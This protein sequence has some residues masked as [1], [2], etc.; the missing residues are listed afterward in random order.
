MSNDIDAQRGQIDYDQEKSS[1]P[2]IIKVIGVGGGGG[3]A[4]NKMYENGEIAGVS[5]L[6]CNTDRQALDSKIVPSKLCI[7]LNTTKGLGAGAEPDRAQKAAEESKEEIKRSITEDETEMVF[8]TAGMGGGTGTG[9]SPIIGQIAMEAGKLT[10][11]IVTVPFL[12]E[13]K[14]KILQALDG[15]SKLRQNVDAILVINNQRLIEIYGER[16]MQEAYALADQTL[17]NA[18]QG[19]SDLVTYTGYVNI[20]FA[21]IHTTL[22]DGGVAIISTGIGEGENRVQKAINNA[23][24]SPLINNNSI[25]NAK[26]ILISTH[27]SKQS[28]MY[29]SELQVI[30]DFTSSLEQE[31]KS[32]LGQYIDETLEGDRIKITILASGFDYQTTEQS[33]L[34]EANSV[35]VIALEDKKREDDERI[36]LYYGES[37]NKIGKPQTARPLIFELD[38]LDDEEL[39]EIAERTP[40]IRRTLT[41]V[42][43]LRKRRRQFQ[44]EQARPNIAPATEQAPSSSTPPRQEET[45]EGDS[46]QKIVFD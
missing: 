36:K 26:R 41:H 1:T 19:I 31:Y 21:D 30:H 16:H 27:E 7:G 46:T 28:P 35:E 3:N 25:R 34:H 23:L 24:E 2:Q 37:A 9:A 6:L 33:L 12:F 11:G 18:V 32:I 10:I 29:T 38:E 42:E 43:E 14:P 8:I 5:F 13:G 15:L 17:S 22:K 44:S 20:D 4:V 39:L 40:A 45:E